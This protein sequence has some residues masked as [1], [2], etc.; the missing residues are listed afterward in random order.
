MTSKR[1][2]IAQTIVVIGLVIISIY[3]ISN[4]MYMS[5]GTM[6]RE[7]ISLAMQELTQITDSNDPE[8][9]RIA[10]LK[11]LAKR[12]GAGT[13]NTRIAGSV[14][15]DG[16]LH[17]YQTPMQEAELVQNIN[18]SLQ[19]HMMMDSCKTANKQYKIAVLAAIVAVFSSLIAWNISKKAK[20]KGNKPL[21]A[22]TNAQKNFEKES[23]S[24]KDSGEISPDKAASTKRSIADSEQ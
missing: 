1:I 10:R 3:I 18:Q 2:L 17:T 12:V 7:E 9:K 15:Y 5:E 11:I 24:I 22:E 8:Q 23:F 4:D 16:A 21:T 6:T 14:E 13:I 20:T 19:T